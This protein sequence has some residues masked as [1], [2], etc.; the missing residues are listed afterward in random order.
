[1]SSGSVVPKKIVFNLANV[2]QKKPPNDFNS[3]T[4][5]FANKSEMPDES[6]MLIAQNLTPQE[7]IDLSMTSKYF[8]KL[9]I[10]NSLWKKFLKPQIRDTITIESPEGLAKEL[11][12]NIDN[13]QDEYIPMYD[14]GLSY[15]KRIGIKSDADISDIASGKKMIMDFTIDISNNLYTNWCDRFDLL[16][17][18]R[19]RVIT[20]T[21]AYYFNFKTETLV[22]LSL[23]YIALK[24]NLITL[25][26]AASFDTMTLKVLLV[27]PNG[28]ELLREKLITIEQ[29]RVFGYIKLYYLVQ[30]NGLQALRNRSITVERASELSIAELNAFLGNPN[31]NECLIL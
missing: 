3:K 6:H 11:F 22:V 14:F 7:L 5:L 15:L 1:M 4:S 26:E 9:C 30:N 18:F 13:V 8:K 25:K 16:N 31:I 21:E 29:A 20:P 23:G 24:E 12:K 2:A 27:S 28:V 10:E 17:L 19:E